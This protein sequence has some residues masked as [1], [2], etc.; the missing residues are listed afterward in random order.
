LSDDASDEKHGPNLR[1]IA[2]TQ[3]ILALLR[4]MTDFVCF[5]FVLA[6]AS[7]PL[8][9]KMNMKG[10]DPLCYCFC[11]FIRRSLNGVT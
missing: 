8:F 7:G 10:L 9:R 1:T 5:T 2:V 3:N 6:L 4:E 11:P